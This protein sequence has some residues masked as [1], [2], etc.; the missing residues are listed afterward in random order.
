MVATVF[1]K[2]KKCLEGMFCA[3]QAIHHQLVFVGEHLV[4]AAFAD[5]PAVFFFPVDGI[6]KILVIG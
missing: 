2:A 5:V 3:V 6:R 4:H 1:A